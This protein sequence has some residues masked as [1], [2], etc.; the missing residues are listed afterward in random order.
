M[1]GLNREVFEMGG[2]GSELGGCEVGGPRSP[3]V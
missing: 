2:G 1:G 3:G